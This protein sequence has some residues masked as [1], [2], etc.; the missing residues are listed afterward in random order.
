MICESNNWNM[1]QILEKLSSQAIYHR[2]W[3]DSPIGISNT[4]GMWWHKISSMFW[5][6]SSDQNIIQNDFQPQKPIKN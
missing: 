5:V 1:L 2:P 4:A 6:M 3:A